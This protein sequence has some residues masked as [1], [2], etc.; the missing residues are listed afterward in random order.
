MLESCE[1]NKYIGCI[2]APKREKKEPYMLSTQGPIVPTP[3]W[4]REPPGT[5]QQMCLS[6]V[7]VK[8]WSISLGWELSGSIFKAREMCSP[9]EGS[10]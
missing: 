10:E 7:F 4:T 2:S 1:L 3:R 5:F 9:S 8:F 6:H